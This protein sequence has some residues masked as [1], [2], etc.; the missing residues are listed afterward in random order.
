MIK[1]ILV[2]I[3]VIAVQSHFECLAEENVTDECLLSIDGKQL[4]TV[5]PELGSYICTILV[6]RSL[7]DKAE[8]VCREAAVGSEDAKYGLF[9]A[10]LN[11]KKILTALQF[12]YEL[13]FQQPFQH[14]RKVS[15]ILE[16]SKPNMEELLYSIEDKV[17]TATL[18]V[19]L[20]R[21]NEAE[22]QLQSYPN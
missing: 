3:L 10:L 14:E 21:Y 2:S 18:L 5:Q 11:N 22:L 9:E 17:E 6:G 20:G 15:E 19:Y 12:E 13:F 1:A 4:V 7:F 16:R 8:E